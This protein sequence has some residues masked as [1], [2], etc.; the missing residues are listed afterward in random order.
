MY[1]NKNKKEFWNDRNIKKQF[2]PSLPLNK[3]PLTWETFEQLEREKN[4][5]LIHIS[6]S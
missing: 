1:C 2:W 4:L 3:E 5:L 6:R